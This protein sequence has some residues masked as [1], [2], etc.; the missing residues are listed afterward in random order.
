MKKQPFLPLFFSDFLG[1]TAEWEGEERA[2]YL[3]LL[4]Y[5]WTLNS[6]PT[7]PKRLAKLIGFDPANFDRCWPVV[8][9]KFVEQDGRF[10]NLK[11]EHHRAN[12]ERISKKRA[13]AG[14]KGGTTTKA[15]SEQLPDSP[16]ADRQAIADI[17]PG[18][19]NQTKP[20]HN[21][22]TQS[23]N[24]SQE[25]PAVACR[26]DL[27][28]Q[29]QQ[30]ETQRQAAEQLNGLGVTITQHHPALKKWLQEGYSLPDM[31]QAVV[32]AR[33]SKPAGEAIPANY[34]T[35][36]LQ[37]QRRGAQETPASV[38]R[39]LW[40]KILNAVRKGEYSKAGFSMG[41]EV[42]SA[43]REIGGFPAIGQCSD[44]KLLGLELAFRKA[45]Q[46]RAAA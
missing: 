40:Q 33:N 38:V 19:P 16:P 45:Y 8:A 36:I 30:E 6:L 42:D 10:Y 24:S 43:V 18:H 7:D 35:P 32:L 9:H 34:L 28:T 1:S 46:A 25:L 14:A 39:E 23:D 26:F 17:L 3:L 37:A 31:Q 21:K 11:L 2:L 27:L 29:T 44:G 41:Q 4:G 15:K 20:N 5:Q 12:A 13:E 22:T